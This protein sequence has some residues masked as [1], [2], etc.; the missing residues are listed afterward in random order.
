MAK[1]REMS[2]QEITLR[3]EVFALK[4]VQPGEAG[5]VQLGC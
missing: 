5:G 4:S 1:E 3:R 2:R